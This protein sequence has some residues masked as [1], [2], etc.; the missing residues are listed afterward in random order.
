MFKYLQS[1]A[2][3]LKLSQYTLQNICEI[4]TWPMAGHPMGLRIIRCTKFPCNSPI[5]SKCLI[6]HHAQKFT[7]WRSIDQDMHEQIELSKHLVMLRMCFE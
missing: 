4:S 5:Q 7:R 6:N 2:Y 1:N 3:A